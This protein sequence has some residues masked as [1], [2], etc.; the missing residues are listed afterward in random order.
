MLQPI[1]LNLLS[2]SI[3]NPEYTIQLLDDLPST[4]TSLKVWTAFVW[5][6][7]KSDLCP[8]LLSAL[9]RWPFKVVQNSTDV[10]LL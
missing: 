4:E 3:T 10:S 1:V 2:E 6:A 8:H 7:Q 9:L 5:S